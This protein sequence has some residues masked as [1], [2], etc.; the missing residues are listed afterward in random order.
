MIL[1]AEDDEVLDYRLTQAVAGTARVLVLPRGGHQ[2]HNTADYA[3]AVAGFLAS[4]GQGG[5]G[6][7]GRHPAPV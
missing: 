4:A 7:S 5:Q 3:E 1:L 2:L 6:G